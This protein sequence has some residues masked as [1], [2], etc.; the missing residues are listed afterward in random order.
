MACAEF[1]MESY[2][3]VVLGWYCQEGRITWNGNRRKRIDAWW[4]HCDG[5][6]I[7]L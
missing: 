5:S 4:R 1:R 7:L 2:V 6:E 3:T